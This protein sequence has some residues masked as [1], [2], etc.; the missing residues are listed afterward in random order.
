MTFWALVRSILVVSICIHPIGL[1]LLGLADFLMNGRSDGLFAVA[2]TPMTLAFFGLP[3]LASCLFVILPT[4]Y[5]LSRYGRREMV[6]FA[7]FVLGAGTLLYLSVARPAPSGA[8]PGYDQALQ[9]FT[10]AT[11]VA[12]ALYAFFRLGLRRA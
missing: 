4:Y 2:A 1:G 5:V 7:V 3:A 9:G 8:L 6:P 10:A 12:W 11:L